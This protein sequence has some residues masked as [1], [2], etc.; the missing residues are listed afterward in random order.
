MRTPLHKCDITYITMFTAPNPQYLKQESALCSKYQFGMVTDVVIDKDG[1]IRKA[2]VKFRNHNENTDRETFHA[3]RSLVV[4]HSID[5]ID[6]MKDLY[7]MAQYADR[8][9]TMS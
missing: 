2:K 7:T 8:E 1:C 9:F 6:I 3:V 4:I 5:D